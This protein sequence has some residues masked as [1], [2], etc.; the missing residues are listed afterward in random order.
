[1]K[2]TEEILRLPAGLAG[3]EALQLAATLFLPRGAPRRLWVCQPGGNMNRHYFDLRPPESEDDSYSFAAQMT[4]RGDAV[5]ALDHLGVGDSDQPEDGWS[6][7]PE[8]L[9]AAAANAIAIVRERFPDLPLLGLGH[10]MGAMMTVLAQAQAEPF[11]GIA[12]LG[13]STRGLPDYVPSALKALDHIPDGETLRPYAQKLF[14]QPYP[15]IHGRG[16]N[17][18]AELFGSGK[19]EP[20]GVA[21][22]KPA[23]AHLLP[24][25]ALRAML[26]GNVASE[27]AAIV[28]PVFLGIG[29][30]DMVGP[31]HEVPL[32]FTRSTGVTL[33]LLAE[34]GH[35]HFLFASRRHLFE[36]LSAWADLHHW[37]GARRPRP[38]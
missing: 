34:T 35:S 31:P 23:T 4:A 6:L 10:S 36:R 13:F 8:R 28:A 18:N 24:L 7:T 19:A 9:A 38:A 33:E 5:L 20:A 26:P 16:G 11:D 2:P 14:G 30:R 27:C 29:E 17:G 3:E 22:L 21:A 37:D 32:A 25:P 12:L 1:M 15:V